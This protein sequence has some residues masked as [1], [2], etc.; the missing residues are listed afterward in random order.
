L[1]FLEKAYRLSKRNKLLLMS[2]LLP[3]AGAF[4][5][6]ISALIW[7]VGVLGGM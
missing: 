2:L 3:I 4:L 6:G 5:A 7:L 1:Y